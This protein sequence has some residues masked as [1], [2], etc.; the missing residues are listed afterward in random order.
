MSKEKNIVVFD[1]ETQKSFAEVSY[2]S[3]MRVAVA[4]SYNCRT[5][6]YQYYTEDNIQDLVTEL[7]EADAVVGYNMISFDY[8]VLSKYTDKNFSNIKSIDLMRII[9]SGLGFRPKLDNI[10]SATIGESKSADGLQSLKWFKEGKMDLIK[11]YCQKDVE[12]TRKVYDFGLDNGFVF[13]FNKNGQKTIVPI[14]W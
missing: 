8:A 3:E 7:F 14:S 4:V 9:Q 11:E 2:I 1:V 13:A 12:V 5:Q 6:T 10:A